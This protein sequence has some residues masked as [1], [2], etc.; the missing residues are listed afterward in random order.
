M[1]KRSVI[2]PVETKSREFHGKLFLALHLLREGHAVLIGEQGRLWE[3]G[4]LVEPAIYLDKSVAATR[5][6]WFQRCRAMGHEA[7][8]WDEEGLVFFDAWL[9]RKQ[10]IDPNAFRQVSRFFAWGEVQCE[11]ICEEYPQ[12]R[13]KISLCGNPRF[14]LLRQDLRAFYRP[15]AEALSRRFGPM[16]LVNTNFAFYNHFKP[17]EEVRQLLAKY[18]VAGEPGYMDKWIEMHRQMHEAY[19]AMAPELVAR[20][21]GHAI[22]V[23]PHPSENHAP[24]I[25]LARSHPRLHID[26]TGNVHE[27]ILAS[28]AVIHFNC[29]TAVE[30]Y[31]LGVPPVAYRPRR[32]PRYENHLPNA[33][34][35][36][37]FSLVEMFA[38][39][40]GRKTARERGALWTEEQD[41]TAARYMAGLSGETA[42]MRISREIAA[43]S[44]T[45]PAKPFSAG[46]RGLAVAKRMWRLPLHAWRAAR[47][48]TDGYAAQKF[49]GMSRAE[50]QAALARMMDVSGVRADYA[51]RRFARN[52]YWLL[53][54]RVNRARSH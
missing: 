46:G 5:A 13:D 49:P 12:F 14:D 19:L 39:L 26:A 34:S 7:V 1:S 31:L 2:I 45:R 47:T 41:R 38:A 10:R 22:V 15:T 20:Y 28:E 17:P 21:P 42:A 18:P 37:A 3:Y 24:W 4:D 36:N 40:D 51:I 11:A 9:Y 25:E 32:Y 29:T 16:I 50:I 44:A 43:L 23:R 6:D 53:P 52:C 27:W 8:S 30:A 54:R 48:P 33:L 35:E